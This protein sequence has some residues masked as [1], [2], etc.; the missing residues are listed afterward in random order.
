MPHSN[1]MTMVS[2]ARDGQVSAVFVILNNFM[3]CL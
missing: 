1:D 3:F 2:C